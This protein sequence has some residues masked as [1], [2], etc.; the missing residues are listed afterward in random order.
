[1]RTYK[2]QKAALTKAVKSKNPDTVVAE[3]T[4][5]VK[6]WKA[7]SIS[8]DPYRPWWPDDWHAWNI[9]YGDAMRDLGHMYAHIDDLP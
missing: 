6:E 3:V 9:A 7:G 4:R 2:G 5:A 1:M 8:G